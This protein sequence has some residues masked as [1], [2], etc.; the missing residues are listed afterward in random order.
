[1]SGN[2]VGTSCGLGNGGSVGGSNGSGADRVD[3]SWATVV[4]RG[5]AAGR[6][7]AATRQS[8]IAGTSSEL[9]YSDAVKLIKKI[10]SEASRRKA[11]VV[12][13]GLPERSATGPTDSA[14]LNEIAFG[15]LDYNL[16]RPSSTPSGSAR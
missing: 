4:G 5:A 1:M 6:V 10:V 3:E 14:R 7:S 12:V 16:Q 15:V 13:S 11:N 9:T 8:S 2:D